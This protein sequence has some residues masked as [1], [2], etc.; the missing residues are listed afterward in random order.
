MTYTLQPSSVV[1][2]K[3]ESIVSSSADYNDYK[4]NHHNAMLS[5]NTY[6]QQ[7]SIYHRRYQMNT[8]TSTATKSPIGQPAYTRT[9]QTAAINQNQTNEA[10]LDDRRVQAEEERKRHLIELERRQKLLEQ[11]RLLMLQRQQEDA[12]AQIG[13]VINVNQPK[14]QP[15]FTESES[16]SVANLA[17]T[18]DVDQSR[19]LHPEYLAH[20]TRLNLAK[21]FSEIQNLRDQLISLQ[22]NVRYLEREKRNYGK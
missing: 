9:F 3:N 1:Q 18:A 4:R 8:R 17:S 15:G 14:Q 20:F 7:Q 21:V 13:R 19:I 12:K 5:S 2:K 16:N 6:D 10:T 11:H 22:E